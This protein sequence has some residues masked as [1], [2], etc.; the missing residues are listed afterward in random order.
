MDQIASDGP[1]IYPVVGASIAN[2]QS[3]AMQLKPGQITRITTGGP[4]PNGATAVVMVEDTSL[5]NT[6]ADG[7]QEESVK[8]HVQARENEW[9]R[10]I[11]SD[12]SVGTVIVRKGELVTAVGGE[13]GVLASVGVREVS[14]IK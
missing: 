1:G 11:G 3:E 12:T 9:I 4:I 10:E 2:S 13:I 6:S 14:I 5:V 8:I 7:L